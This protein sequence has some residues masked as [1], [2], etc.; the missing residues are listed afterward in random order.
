LLS[1]LKKE[2]N[3]KI[4]FNI[5]FEGHSGKKR[6]NDETDRQTLTLPYA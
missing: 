1:N 5:R 3:A 4:L 6:E 2:L